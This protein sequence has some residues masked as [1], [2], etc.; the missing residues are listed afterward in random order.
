GRDGKA[1]VHIPA[2]AFPVMPKFL[3]DIE[4]DVESGTLYVSDSGDL[5]GKDGAIYR[6][7]P[8][9]KVSLVLDGKKSP[10]VK[11]PNGLA[12]DGQSHLL[13]NDLVSGEL[14]RIKLAD[15][16]TEKLAEGFGGS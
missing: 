12:M 16:S 7:D 14:H 1:T 2:S 6:I 4:V 10:A 9:K 3:N 5:E 8:K 13:F 15:G 11:G